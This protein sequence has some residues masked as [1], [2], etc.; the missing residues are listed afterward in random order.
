MS[1]LIFIDENKRKK[2]RENAIKGAKQYSHYL[3]DKDFLVIC[4]DGTEHILHFYKA[5]F[6]HLTGIKSNLNDDDFFTNCEN[7]H[8][9][10]GNISEYQ[11]YNWETLNSK[12]KRIV[13]IHRIVYDN[14]Q[15]TLFLINLHTNTRNFP[16]AI[17]NT[18]I[19]TCVGFLNSNNKARTLRKYSSSQNAEE[20][21]KIGL[22]V[23]KKDNTTLYNELIYVSNIKNIYDA[24]NKIMDKLS[25][26]LQNKFLEILTKPS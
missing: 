11:K 7:R 16:V 2:L 8:L 18:N 9:D 12:S 1:H 25:D 24:N 23:A 20:E 17:K 3:T 10:L 19:D 14:I 22:I 13:K 21:K 5:D 4:E 26:G 6:K 15:N